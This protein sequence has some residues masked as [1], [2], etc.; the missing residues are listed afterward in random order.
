MTERIR[1]IA[2]G[3]PAA[4]AQP[5]AKSLSE[6]EAERLAVK[7]D[8]YS[9]KVMRSR[10]TVDGRPYYRIRLAGQTVPGTPGRYTPTEVRD[11]MIDLVR[12]EQ[13]LQRQADAAKRASVE[14]WTVRRLMAAWVGTVVRHI[15]VDATR[16][17]NEQAAWRLA[18]AAGDLRLDRIHRDTLKR[19]AA[20]MLKPGFPDEVLAYRRTKGDTNRTATTRECYATGTVRNTMTSLGAAW[21]WA[22]ELGHAPPVVPQL[23]TLE[24]VPV[25]V[26]RMPTRDEIARVIAWLSSQC[27]VGQHPVAQALTIQAACGARVGEIARLT[28]ESVIHDDGEIVHLRIR[29]KRK[30]R[31]VPVLGEAAQLIRDLLAAAPAGASLFRWH[32]GR[33]AGGPP[34][35]TFKDTIVNTLKRVVPW[36]LLGIERFG[37]HGI[38]DRFINDA[39]DNGALIG[40]VA[41][42]CGN[43][44]A[45]IERHYRQIRPEQVASV[46]ELVAAVAEGKVVAIHRNSKP[47]QIAGGQ[48]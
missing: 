7:V 45:T 3:T 19:I 18:A 31:T 20:G 34:G 28:T 40:V 37:S 4:Y 10:G 44:P 39:L 30:T 35:S 5:M 1:S 21:R 2:A 27:P 46:V 11:R 23:P 8:P 14:P 16:T 15:D 25:N 22:A 38:R 43:S 26:S 36:D 29:S 47:E 24:Q 32:F 6:D 12:G 41:E 48:A 9:A 13:E 17:N 33:M 42:C